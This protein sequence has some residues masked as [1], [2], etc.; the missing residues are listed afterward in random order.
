ML[1][2][3]KSNIKKVG[4]NSLPKTLSTHSIGKLLRD[5]GQSMTLPKPSSKLKE[6]VMAQIMADSALPT[7]KT[8]PVMLAKLL[9]MVGL[10]YLLLLYFH[11]W[12]M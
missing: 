1:K 7:S 2:K 12:V 5:Y 8:L 4:S 11:G 3:N 9:V 10:S 6:R